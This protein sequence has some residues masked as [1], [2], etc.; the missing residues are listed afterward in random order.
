MPGF[1]TLAATM[2]VGGGA[3]MWC[4]WKVRNDMTNA[5]ICP[6]NNPLIH[7]SGTLG[8]YNWHCAAPAC[9]YNVTYPMPIIEMLLR[10]KAPK[11]GYPLSIAIP[12]P[13]CECRKPMGARRTLTEKAQHYTI[14]FNLNDNESFGNLQLHCATCQMRVNF[15]SLSQNDDVLYSKMSPFTEED[16]TNPDKV[17]LQT[18]RWMLAMQSNLIISSGSNKKH[19]NESVIYTLLSMFRVS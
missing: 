12:R 11:P 8:S 16:M 10:T 13:P 1:G 19:S 6:C 3:K 17:W 14:R 9:E 7:Q 4:E 5:Y 15:S 18:M 2:S